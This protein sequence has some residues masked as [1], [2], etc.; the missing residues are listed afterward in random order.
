VTHSEHLQAAAATALPKPRRRSR[1]LIAVLIAL[2]AASAVIIQSPAQAYVGTN[3]E[4]NRTTGKCLDSNDDGA[5]YT[6]PC[7]IPIGSNPHQLWEPIF[8][9]NDNWADIVK[10]KNVETG[11]CITLSG[12]N[13]ITTQQCGGVGQLWAANGLGWADVVFESYNSFNSLCIDSYYTGP[14]VYPAACTF[15]GPQHWSFGY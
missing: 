15:R 7:S 4:R 14:S 1:S 6:L 11:R 2:V 5:V 9:G 10:M 12:P 13:W 3:V 8:Q